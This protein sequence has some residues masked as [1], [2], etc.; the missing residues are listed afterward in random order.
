MTRHAEVAGGGIGGLSVATMLA[1]SGWTVR[2]HERAPEIREAGTGIFLKNNAVEVLEEAGM[3][4]ELERRAFRL[5]RSVTVDSRGNVTG[6]RPLQGTGRLFATARENVI[7]SLYDSALAAGV[8]VVLDS[9]VASADPAGALVLESGTRLEADLVVAADGVNSRVRESL[10]VDCTVRLLPTVINRYMLQTREVSE[11]PDMVEHWSG[12]YRVATAPCGENLT[13]AFQVYPEADRAAA[14]A[15]A[16]MSAWRE[17]FPRLHR[18][19]D[20]MAEQ[21]PISSNYLVVR[22]SPWQRGRVAIVGDSAHGMPPTLGQGAGL[23][24]MNGRALVAVLDRA[25]SVEAA[26]PVWEQAV[27]GIA[28]STQR[29]AMRYDRITRSWPR[30][31]RFLRPGALWAMKSVPAVSRRML[32]ADRGLAATDIEV[33][34]LGAP[35][36]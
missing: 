29:W 33:T 23:T 24:V 35:Q 25:E 6:T 14:A 5:E 3:F 31:L 30:P 1:R 15:P 11:T 19:F 20:L 8:E 13:Y 18:L 2:V 16:D 36:P 12:R 32:V 21:R 17:A 28:D 4:E 34:P 26:L 27:R 10:G 22:T 7:Q 9:P